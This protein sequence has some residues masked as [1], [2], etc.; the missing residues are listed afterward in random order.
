ML[1]LSF[2]YFYILFI[3][4]IYSYYFIILFV[5]FLWILDENEVV[6]PP[7]P[8]AFSTMLEDSLHPALPHSSSQAPLTSHSPSLCDPNPMD[9]DAR[10]FY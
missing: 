6:V 9:T 10:N 4:I 7:E 2:L 5:L 3:V 8:Q 1:F